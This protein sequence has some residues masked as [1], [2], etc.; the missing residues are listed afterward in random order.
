MFCGKL[1]GTAEV[2]RCA[3][4]TVLIAIHS[5]ARFVV[6]KQLTDMGLVSHMDFFDANEIFPAATRIS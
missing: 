2:V 6:A 5:S 3:N 4:Y 1:V